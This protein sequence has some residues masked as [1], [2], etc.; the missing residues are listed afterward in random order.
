M[1][2]NSDDGNEVHRLKYCMH[3]SMYLITLVC[4]YFTDYMLHDFHKVT[5]TL[6]S[7]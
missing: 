1:S 6:L 3:H 5:G 4:S 7:C 2:N